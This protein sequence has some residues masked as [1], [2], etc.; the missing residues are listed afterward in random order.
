MSRYS[1]P[2]DYSGGTTPRQKTRE[3]LRDEAEE[4]SACTPYERTAAYRRSLA[5]ALQ[6]A[7]DST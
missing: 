7:P 5:Q 4:R 1:G 2:G 3:Q 6:P